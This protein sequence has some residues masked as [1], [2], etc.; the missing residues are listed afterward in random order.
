MNNAKKQIS[1]SAL[2]NLVGILLGAALNLW[3]LPK[4]FSTE[5]LGM[6]RWMERSA[7]LLSNI[8]AFW[9]T[10]FLHKVSFRPV[11]KTKKPLKVAVVGRSTLLMLS[12]GVW[13]FIAGPLLA[14]LFNGNPDTHAYFSFKP[15]M[16]FA[17]LPQLF[18]S[19]RYGLLNGRF[20]CR[21]YKENCR[22]SIH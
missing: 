12:V 7:V 8:L 14:P 16:L 13:V 3:L 9:R 4:L 20:C 21:Y 22:T 11:R 1:S 10:P 18:H 2:I 15:K 17:A 19:Q 5:E 6:Y